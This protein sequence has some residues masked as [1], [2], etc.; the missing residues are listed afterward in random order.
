MSR[1]L[2]IRFVSASVDATSLPPVRDLVLA[3]LALAP[4]SR[5]LARSPTC[6]TRAI[7]PIALER[8]REVREHRAL[9]RR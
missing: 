8:K 4:A 7:E 3:C 5:G 2:Q 6:W 1:A 9:H